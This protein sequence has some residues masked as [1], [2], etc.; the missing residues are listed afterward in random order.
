MQ[1]APFFSRGLCGRIVQFGHS[2]LAYITKYPFFV[3][4][5]TPLPASSAEGSQGRPPIVRMRLRP[6]SNLLVWVCIGLALI[7]FPLSSNTVWACLGVVLSSFW[8]AT[9]LWR[10]WSLVQRSSEMSGLIDWFQFT[11]YARARA[12][13]NVWLPCATIALFAACI[14]L[15]ENLQERMDAPARMYDHWQVTGTGAAIVAL[16]LLVYFFPKST[17]LYLPALDAWYH[18]RPSSVRPVIDDSTRRPSPYPTRTWRTISDM[19]SEVLSAG[20][21][22]ALFREDDD[23]PIWRR[24]TSSVV[25][26]FAPVLIPLVV[27]FATPLVFNVWRGSPGMDN[28]SKLM[29]GVAS[30]VWAAWSVAYFVAFGERDFMSYLRR[31]ALQPRE[32]LANTFAFPNKMTRR[33]AAQFFDGQGATAFQ[34][35]SFVIVP[36]YAGYLGLFAAPDSATARDSSPAS[37]TSIKAQAWSVNIHCKVN[38]DIAPSA[39][40]SASAA[41]SQPFKRIRKKSVTQPDCAKPDQ[42]TAR[43]ADMIDRSANAASQADPRS[44]QSTEP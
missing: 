22:L 39:S 20:T 43:P 15:A 32:A 30:F 23:R 27:L 5:L 24:S 42:I 6:T 33:V 35:L 12:R 44:A 38:S 2:V 31:S 18:D 1:R 9:L 11:P 7:S 8:L 19:S 16:Y 34:F 13:T 41:S 37:V 21:A 4:K 25:W 10:S 40:M 28:T 29:L 14:S 26:Y 17:A 36:A 3:V